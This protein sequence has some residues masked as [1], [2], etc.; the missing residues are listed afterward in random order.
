MDSLQSQE[1]WGMTYFVNIIINL[2]S[3][4]DKMLKLMNAKKLELEN[5]LFKKRCLFL[6]L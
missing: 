1:K 5:F 2:I 4:S 3:V 6:L